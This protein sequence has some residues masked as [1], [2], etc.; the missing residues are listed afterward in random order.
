MMW[1]AFGKGAMEALKKTWMMICLKELM[2]SYEV[3]VCSSGWISE[4][5]VTE[6]WV[7]K[8]QNNNK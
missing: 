4:S 1:D 8:L 7:D 5:S 2:N 3:N 6:L